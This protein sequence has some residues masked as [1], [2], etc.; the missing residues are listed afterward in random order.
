MAAHRYTI[1]IHGKIFNLALPVNC[2]YTSLGLNLTLQDIA[3]SMSKNCQKLDFFFLKLSFFVFKN[4]QRQVFETN[5][6]FWQFFNIQM[7]IF[8]R[9]R[10]EYLSSNNMLSLRDQ[11]MYVQKYTIVKIN[12]D[13]FLF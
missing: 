8:W 4:C 13:I 2:T 6:H 9:F 7:A 5:D 12:R 3:I 1:K 11:L 10:F